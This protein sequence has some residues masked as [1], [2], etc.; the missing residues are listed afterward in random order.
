MRTSDRTGWVVL[1]ADIQREHILPR[2]GT[3]AVDERRAVLATSRTV[4]AACPVRHRRPGFGETH[5]HPV[6]MPAESACA[7]LAIALI[8]ARP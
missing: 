8:H 7:A 2:P 3:S 6:G 5:P 1:R 4:P